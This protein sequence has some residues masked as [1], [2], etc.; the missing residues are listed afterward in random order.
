M[1][2][3]SFQQKEL[4]WNPTDLIPHSSE[5]PPIHPETCEIQNSIVREELS[6]EMLKRCAARSAAVEQQWSSGV[7]SEF[8]VNVFKAKLLMQILKFLA[9]D[10]IE[11][12][13]DCGKP[14]ST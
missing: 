5:A 2:T 11:S 8:K 13:S 3:L 6:S 10:A 9:C 12:G 7:E 14:E 1:H 4:P